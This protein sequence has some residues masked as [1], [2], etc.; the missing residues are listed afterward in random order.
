MSQAGYTPIQLYHSTVAGAEP[1]AADMQVGE[2]AINVT[3]KLLFTKNGSNVIVGI[4]GGATGGGPD[5]V[6]VQNQAIVTTSFTLTTGFNAE[7]VGPITINSGVTV[8]VPSNQRWV[9]L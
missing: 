6:F 2:L 5:Q 4:S 3:D 8:T 9:I 1:D 7:S